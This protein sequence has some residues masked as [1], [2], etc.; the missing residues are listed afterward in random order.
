M[1]QRI[2]VWRALQPAGVAA[3]ARA[4][5]QRRAA[6]FAQLVRDREDA[7]WEELVAEFRRNYYDD[8]FDEVVPALFATDDPLIIYNLVRSLDV[9]QPKELDAL[10]RFVE[11][12]A[13]EKHQA[14]LRVV[15]ETRRE[16]LLTALRHRTELPQLV[17]EALA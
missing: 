17:Q 16:E 10:M 7:C 9:S 14:S 13:V 1:H 12:C 3:Q 11:E 2:T 6:A 15:A 8:A 4:P 5:E